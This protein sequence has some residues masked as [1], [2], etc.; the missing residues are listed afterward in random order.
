MK[1]FLKGL[2][3]LVVSLTVVSLVFFIGTR[4]KTQPEQPE[5]MNT[6]VSVPQETQKETGRINTLVL[7]VDNDGLRTDTIVLVSYD[8]DKNDVNVL[9]IPRDTRVYIENGYHKINAAHAMGGSEGSLKAVQRLTGIPIDYYVEFTC[10]AFREV[11]DA[12]GGVDF[13]VSR[14]MKYT[15]PEQGLYINLKKG[16]QHLDGDKAE[17]LVRF[18][19]YPEGDIARVR[20]QQ[21][22]FQALASQ[23][24]NPGMIKNLP[25]LYQAL[26]KNIQSN[27]TAADVMKYLPNLSELQPDKVRMH[28]LPGHYND[29]DYGTSYW[30]CDKADTDRLIRQSF[31]YEQGRQTEKTEQQPAAEGG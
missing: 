17:Q 21:E 6:G 2:S 8:L 18:R 7:G 31:G 30:I 28:R 12:L 20:T 19:K 22:F 24:L 29:T 26:R 3:V 11:I 15:D 10:S 16:Y 9:S 5:N 23:K 1:L 13:D 27:I 25:K 4:G 14:D